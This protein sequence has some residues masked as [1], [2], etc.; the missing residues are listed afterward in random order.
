VSDLVSDPVSD[1][2]AVSHEPEDTILAATKTIAVVGLSDRHDRP[3][4]RVTRYMQDHGYRIVPV[5][6]EID[7][8]ILGEP[9]VPSLADLPCAV[10]LVNVFR[11]SHLTDAPIDAAIAIGAPAVWLQLGIT[12]DP[13]MQRARDAGLRAVQDLCLMVEHRRWIESRA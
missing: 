13:G 1:V 7:G 2:S 5:N 9:V 8:A 3:S 6:P 12:N 10:D 4:Y 11:R